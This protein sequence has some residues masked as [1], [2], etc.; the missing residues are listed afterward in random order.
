MPKRRVAEDCVISQKSV[1]LC[2]N[3]QCRRATVP[4]LGR[5]GTKVTAVVNPCQGSGGG[6]KGRIP[7]MLCT[8]CYVRPMTWN[9]LQWSWHSVCKCILLRGVSRYANPIPSLLCSDESCC[10]RCWTGCA[11][12]IPRYI[13]DH[14]ST[15]S[16]YGMPEETMEVA[17]RMAVDL[18]EGFKDAGCRRPM[19]RNLHL[20]WHRP[21]TR[22]CHQMQ[23]RCYPAVV[24]CAEYMQ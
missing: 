15:M 4:L 6:H 14:L 23:D 13:S 17:G 24:L 5:I 9:A 11:M 22:S 18:A 2:A 3:L 8:D 12:A 1:V 20:A 19:C 7:P 10:L 21:Q 16:A